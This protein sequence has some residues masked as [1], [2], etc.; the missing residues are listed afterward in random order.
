MGI[1]KK[2]FNYLEPDVLIGEV[3]HNNSTSYLGI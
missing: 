3:I 2:S 1:I